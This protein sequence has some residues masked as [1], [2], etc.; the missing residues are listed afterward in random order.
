M[1]SLCARRAF[2]LLYYLQATLRLHMNTRANQ[3]NT[4]NMTWWT[5][6][7][8]FFLFCFHFWIFQIVFFFLFFWFCSRV[9]RSQSYLFHGKRGPLNFGNV[10]LVCYINFDKFKFN[11][12]RKKMVSI[13]WARNLKII[14]ETNNFWSASAH[15]RPYILRCAVGCCY[16]YC[17]SSTINTET[18]HICEMWIGMPT[19]FFI[20]IHFLGFAPPNV[21]RQHRIFFCFFIFISSFFSLFWFLCWNRL[22]LRKKKKKEKRK[23]N[24]FRR[25]W[26]RCLCFFFFFVRCF[27]V[28]RHNVCHI[29]RSLRATMIKWNKHCIIKQPER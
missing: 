2:A 12:D 22:R 3:W 4:N 7:Q 8:S 15:R 25:R 14:R 17:S 24:S 21:E 29:Q 1:V 18:I 11:N 27:L 13:W 9:V 16:C 5:G 28:W 10:K 26:S 20:Y 6:D 19:I 23:N